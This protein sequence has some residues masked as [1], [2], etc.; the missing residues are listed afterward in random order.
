MGLRVIR[1]YLRSSSKV[2]RAGS[3]ILLKLAHP[4][5]ISTDCRTKHRPPVDAPIYTA[6]RRIDFPRGR[7][8]GWLPGSRD[9]NGPEQSIMSR[10]RLLSPFDLSFPNNVARD[11]CL[12]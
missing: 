11:L 10:L 6:V 2:L 3:S 12:H 9:T 1:V 7:Y 5:K 4:G 8:L